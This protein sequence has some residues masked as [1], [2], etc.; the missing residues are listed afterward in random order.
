M[1]SITESV[2]RVV[3]SFSFWTCSCIRVKLFS[4]NISRMLD[5]TCLFADFYLD[6]GGNL[7]LKLVRQRWNLTAIQVCNRSKTQKNTLLTVSQFESK[8][9]VYSPGKGLNLFIPR[10]LDFMLARHVDALKGHDGCIRIIGTSSQLLLM[11]LHLLTHSSQKHPQ[12]R[13]SRFVII[14]RG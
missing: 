13:L 2:L 12:R 5:D 6:D 1:F 14:A 9:V 3:I 4:G 11:S 10:N 7:N 8:V